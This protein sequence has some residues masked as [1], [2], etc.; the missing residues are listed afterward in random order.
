MTLNKI[1]RYIVLFG[2]FLIPFVPLVVSGTMLFPSTFFPFITGKNFI[3]RIVVEL[4]A[5]AW[6]ILAMRD[7]TFLPKK[8]WILWAIAAF[9]GVMTVADFFSANPYKSFWSNY[10]RMEG[11]VTLLHLAAYFLVA[12]TVLNTQKLWNWFFHTSIGVSL[13]MCFYGILQYKGELGIDQGSTRLDGTIGNA[14]YLAVY[15]L[16]HVFLLVYFCISRRAQ[17]KNVVTSCVIA[18]GSFIVFYIAH[19]SGPQSSAHITGGILSLISV[20]G[21]IGAIYFF[22]HDFTEK[23]SFIWQTIIYAILIVFESLLMIGTATRGAIIGLLIGLVFIAAMLA[24]FEK[25][26]RALKITGISALVA[27]ALCVVI[28]FGIKNTPFV[29]K[30]PILS[31]LSS[32]ATLDVKKF[33]DTE[34]SSRLQIWTMAVQG[35]KERPILGWGQESFNYLFYKYYSPAMYTQ[36]PWFDRAHNVLLDWLVAGGILGLITYL[37][38]FFFT[39]FYLWGKKD[40][41]KLLSLGAAVSV[42]SAIV[43][44]IFYAMNIPE[45]WGLIIS[46]IVTL[47]AIYSVSQKYPL[48]NKSCVEPAVLTGLLI[49]YFIHNLFVFDN[50]ASY[51]L[52]F[53]IIAYVHFL[54]GKDFESALLSGNKKAKQEDP[55]NAMGMAAVAI[56]GVCT[57]LVVYFINVPAL[58][59]SISL[60]GALSPQPGGVEQ[61]LSIYQDIFNLNSYG[62]YEAREQL[63]QLALKIKGANAPETVQTEVFNLAYTQ[64]QEQLKETPY[65]VRYLYFM[66]S[67]LNVYGKFSDALPIWQKALTLSPNRQ[68]ILL[69]LAQV[70]QQ[71]GD[72]TDAAIHYKKA[73]D[74]EPDYFDAAA[75][76]FSNSGQYP[77]LLTL[78]T[79]A[80][81][82]DPTNV[83]LKL[84]L[85]NT[86]VQMHDNSSA[87]Q[88]L[89][90]MIKNDSSFTAQGNYYINQI[91]TGKS[92]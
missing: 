84:S 72:N 80:I 29:Q 69:N 28:F 11:L 51:I 54:H 45:I 31:R 21:I 27:L 73:Y 90:T 22:F 44:G 71:L 92:L 62:N 40:F 88:L 55:E 85:V 91:Q 1:L 60:V 56:I 83:N 23:V 6:L 53:S 76:Y 35:I 8:S 82:N 58:R 34:G 81:T 74:L 10:E 89:K 57:F 41:W 79:T 33:V 2:I 16:I 19:I 30:S 46:V 38:L 14:T 3:F 7:R 75:Q 66:G 50:I 52:F 26:K 70:E 77:K 67:L 63:V 87:I 43:L 25:E 5:G 37:S 12:A 61:N 24:F 47:G 9:L 39:L 4:I 48:E 13:F 68:L 65:D 36:E 64:M 15:L 49:A 20:L 78:L 17:L 59:A 32:L 18:F 42:F 86:Y